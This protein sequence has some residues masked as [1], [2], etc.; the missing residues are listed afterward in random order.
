MKGTITARVPQRIYEFLEVKYFFET[1][2]ERADAIKDAVNDCI[3]LEKAVTGMLLAKKQMAAITDPKGD[4][5]IS[6]GDK[7]MGVTSRTKIGKIDWRKRN[8]VWEYFKED[9]QIWVGKSSVTMP[10]AGS[11]AADGT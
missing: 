10:E 2:E 8:G 1:P 3:E 6:D 9:E 11:E 4:N 7:Q 5:T